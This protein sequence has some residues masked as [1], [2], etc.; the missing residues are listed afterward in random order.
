MSQLERNLEKA[1]RNRRETMELLIRIAIYI[2]VEFTVDDESIDEPRRVGV[3]AL[4]A[5]GS[6]EWSFESRFWRKFRQSRE[7]QQ[8]EQLML[9]GE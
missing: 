7:I 4:V 2:P 1:N 6:F 9:Y 5:E 3:V 8:R